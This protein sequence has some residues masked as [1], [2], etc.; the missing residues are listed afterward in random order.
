MLYFLYNL[1]SLF[2][3]M[4]QL[5]NQLSSLTE[6]LW[7]NPSVS[8]VLLRQSNL[9]H[10]CNWNV[11]NFHCFSRSLICYKML[12]FDNFFK[13]GIISECILVGCKLRVSYK[14]LIVVWIDHW[15]YGIFHLIKW[16]FH[17]HLL[18]LQNGFWHFEQIIIVHQIASCFSRKSYGYAAIYNLYF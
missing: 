15:Q 12:I 5:H 3:D 18:T 16:H 1:F 14:L 9:S 10:N 8:A 11:S 6:I 17:I 13:D 2:T 4:I 7:H